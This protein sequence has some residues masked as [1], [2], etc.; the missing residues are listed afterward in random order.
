MKKHSS[1]VGIQVVLQNNVCYY[2]QRNNTLIISKRS[3]KK[4]IDAH[5][6]MDLH[7]SSFLVSKLTTFTP[8]LYYFA[9]CKGALLIQNRYGLAYEEMLMDE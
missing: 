3:I 5:G 8:L 2:D 9:I 4:A 1:K 6:E 7:F